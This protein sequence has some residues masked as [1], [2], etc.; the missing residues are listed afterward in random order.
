MPAVMV[1]RKLSLLLFYLPID[2]FFDRFSE[3]SNRR[4][5]WS[6]LF[7]NICNTNLNE[8]L[9]VVPLRMAIMARNQR[10]SKAPPYERTQKLQ[11]KFNKKN[12]RLVAAKNYQQGLDT[13]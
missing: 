4:I 7:V 5:Y 13:W 12:R 2:G 9:F 11:A 8:F 10:N 6:Y 1:L 3:F